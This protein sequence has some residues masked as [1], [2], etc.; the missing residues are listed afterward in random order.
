MD[1]GKHV[2]CIYIK[3]YFPV[4]NVMNFMHCLEGN[5]RKFLL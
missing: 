2:P 1:I 5:Y 4:R 3:G